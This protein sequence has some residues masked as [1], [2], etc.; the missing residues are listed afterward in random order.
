MQEAHWPPRSQYSFCCPN[1]WGGGY[2]IPGPGPNGGGGTPS[3]V[4]AGEYPI[5]GWGCPIP[6]KGYSRVPLSGPSQGT[7][8]S[9]PGQGYPI[10]GRG[11]PRVP[12]PPIQTWVGYPLPSGP[13]R[14]V[15]L[16][17]DL[18][19]VPPGVDWQSENITSRLVLR[20]RSV[21][22]QLSSTVTEIMS[23]TCLRIYTRYNGNISRN[24]PVYC[25]W[26]E[27]IDCANDAGGNYTDDHD[28][29]Q[30][31]MAQL[32]VLWLRRHFCIWQ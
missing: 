24:K 26:P 27:N 13:G 10:H 8:L 22:T 32:C 30:V 31:V 15:P 25:W 28:D 7:P 1:G 20:T 17:L 21:K 12:P 9:G 19:V 5:P 6:G 14:G 29:P 23:S 11:Y 4:Q 2:P 3:W 16:H 18:A